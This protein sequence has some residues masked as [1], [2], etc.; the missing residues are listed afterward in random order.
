MQH[1]M[2]KDMYKEIAQRMLKD[3]YMAKEEEEEGRGGGEGREE[4]EG[5]ERKEEENRRSSP[6]ISPHNPEHSC[7]GNQRCCCRTWSLHSQHSP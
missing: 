5:E 6:D 1:H 3:M 4:E 2:L 7:Q